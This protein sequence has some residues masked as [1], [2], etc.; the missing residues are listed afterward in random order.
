MLRLSTGLVFF[1]DRHVVRT[2]S[3][4]EQ[5][6][7]EFKKRKTIRPIREIYKRGVCWYLDESDLLAFYHLPLFFLPVT[8]REN[9]N[10]LEMDRVREREEVRGAIGSLRR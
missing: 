4:K 8:N 7:Q 5:I 6:K 9:G 3:T 10:P 1:L 2:R